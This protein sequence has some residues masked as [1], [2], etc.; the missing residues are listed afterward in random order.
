MVYISTSF[1]FPKH[2]INT[3]IIVI[4]MMILFTITAIWHLHTPVWKPLNYELLKYVYGVV[5]CRHLGVNG[6]LI[7]HRK[8]FKAP[9]NQSRLLF[10]LRLKGCRLVAVHFMCI[11]YIRYVILLWIQLV[12]FGERTTCLS[13]QWQMWGIKARYVHFQLFRCLYLDT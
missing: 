1:T 5:T 2:V 3:A 9:I 7:S 8:I 4:T 12:W 13:D 6:N 11:L 10:I